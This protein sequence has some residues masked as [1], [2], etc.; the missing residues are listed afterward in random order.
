MLNKINILSRIFKSIFFQQI[1]NYAVIYVDGRCN[2]HCGFCIHAAVDARK[3]PIIT[4]EQ[5]GSVFKKANS[6]LHLTITGGEPL[7][8]NFYQ[9]FNYASKLYFNCFGYDW[10]F[11]VVIC[12]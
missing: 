3:T 12:D 8:R 1:P 10:F 11:C 4:P 5:W 6:L 2:M 9:D 7:V